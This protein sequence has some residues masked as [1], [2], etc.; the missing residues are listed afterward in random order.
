MVDCNL[1]FLVN[2]INFTIAPVVMCLE[3]IMTYL[4]GLTYEMPEKSIYWAVLRY[5]Q[6]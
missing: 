6:R 1:T 4:F 3:K 2:L 5:V